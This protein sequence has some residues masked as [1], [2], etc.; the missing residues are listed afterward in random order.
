VS[1]L[2]L[3]CDE[4]KSDVEYYV[5]HIFRNDFEM[6]NAPALISLHKNLFQGLITDAPTRK[7]PLEDDYQ[8]MQQVYV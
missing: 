6:I 5:S 7:V 2:L 3:I 1:L 8:P 4:I